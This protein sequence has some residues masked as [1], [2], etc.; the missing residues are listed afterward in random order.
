MADI[1]PHNV[2]LCRLHQQTA[3]R[4]LRREHVLILLL[5]HQPLTG[6]AAM[7]TSARLI[8]LSFLTFGLLLTGCDSSGDDED[9]GNGVPFAETWSS[10]RI[11]GGFYGQGRVQDPA[12]F[13]D[14]S[15]GM[16]GVTDEGDIVGTAT[17]G[18]NPSDPEFTV[19]G[20]YNAPNLTLET[21]PYEDPTNGPVKFDCTFQ[22]ETVM[23]CD[24]TAREGE[25]DEETVT[26]L[27]FTS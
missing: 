7:K 13:L 16:G 3:P 22:S 25:R 14:F 1:L 10:G 8:T 24:V 2:Q 20:P 26:D 6:N 12:I 27:T 5:C 23:E 11:E 15:P 18:T 19:I 17:I 4:I 21:A 9:D